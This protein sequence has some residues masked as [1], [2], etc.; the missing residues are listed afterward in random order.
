MRG[1]EQDKPEW[2]NE[3]MEI[4]PDLKAKKGLLFNTKNVDG[5][6]AQKHLEENKKKN[7]D[8]SKEFTW[9][10]VIGQGTFG[11]VYKACYTN[12]QKHIVAIKKVYQDPKY[13]NREFKIVKELDHPNCIKVSSPFLSLILDLVFL[14][15]L[16]VSNC[17]GL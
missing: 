15:L 6:N 10:K 11:V 1:N 3:D 2:H 16:S 12:N 14:N 5:K 13:S 7:E 9:I 8:I 17:S 4:D